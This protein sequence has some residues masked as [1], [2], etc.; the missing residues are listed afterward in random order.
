MIMTRA[1]PFLLV[2]LSECLKIAALQFRGQPVSAYAACGFL[3]AWTI[4][5]FSQAIPSWRESNSRFM[6]RMIWQCWSLAGV[7][8]ALVYPPAWHIG[9]EITLMTPLFIVFPS[10]TNGEFSKTLK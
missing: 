5:V 10:L 2:L 3:V 6:C 8:I 1:M 7:L 9:I 4:Y